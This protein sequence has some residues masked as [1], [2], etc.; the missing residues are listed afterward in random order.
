MFRYLSIISIFLIFTAVL[1][2]GCGGDDEEEGDLVGPDMNGEN[3][4]NGYASI[5]SSGSWSEYTTPGGEYKME[6]IGIDTLE[7]KQCYVMEYET[8]ESGQLS[9]MQIWIDY[10]TQ[11]TAFAFMKQGNK[12]IRMDMDI[13]DVPGMV[14]ENTEKYEKIG[15]GQYTTPTGKTVDTTKYKITDQYGVTENEVSSEVPFSVV[16]T[17]DNGEVTTT[18]YDFGKDGA[19][20]SISK[21][22]A[23]NAEPLGIPDIGGGGFPDT[24][25]G[26]LPDEPDNNP[27]NG[28]DI[29][30][31]PN[32][33]DVPDN[34]INPGDNQDG[35]III[36]VGAGANPSIQISQPVHVLMVSKGFLPVWG[37]TAND[38]QGP[39]LAGP[40]QYGVV[41][42]NAQADF[43]NAPKMVAGETYT[44]QAMSFKGLVPV[45]GTLT[46]VR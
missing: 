44:I 13:S 7:G 25:G 5:P 24:G 41:P 11:T 33:P 38:E 22:E 14:E 30:N 29:P 21:Q 35:D 12:V 28:G 2:T 20:R 39:G 8:T 23:E 16:K 19:T 26:D 34:Q 6:S 9:I 18:L 31:V 42:V 17:T 36:T 1:L 40:F 4:G 32:Q 15:D 43:P 10:T 37:F 27:G 45:M 3:P 46:F